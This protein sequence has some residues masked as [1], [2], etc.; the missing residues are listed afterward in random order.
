MGAL[1]TLHFGANRMERS[2]YWR[3]GGADRRL[4]ENGGVRRKAQQAMP[5][6]FI[7][8]QED[9]AQALRDFVAD[10]EIAISM[11]LV[12]GRAKSRKLGSSSKRFWRRHFRL[13]RISVQTMLS[14]ADCGTVFKAPPVRLP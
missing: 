7:P 5:S 6:T 13:D 9:A 3:N 1:A 14:R 2:G 4:E 8:G 10:N 12:Q 11:L